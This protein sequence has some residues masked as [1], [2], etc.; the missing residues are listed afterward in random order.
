M[1]ANLV[2]RTINA[3]LATRRAIALALLFIAFGAI[4]GIVWLGAGSIARQRLEIVE[5][6]ETA[7]RLQAIA[8]LKPGLE[9][10]AS[11]A[12]SAAASEDFLEGESEAVIRANLQAQ[13]NSIAAA[14]N[15]TLQ[16]VSNLPELEIDGARFIGMRADLSGTVE[17]VHNTVFAI[18]TVKP[19]VI[20][21]TSIW[22][23][24]ADQGIGATQA[25][26]ISTQ[27]RIYGALSPD[28]KSPAAQVA[29]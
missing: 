24:G 11:L 14:Q 6:R 13:L 19:L 21:D 12:T 1:M 23:S 3:S 22:L 16:S 10:E 28:L 15:A 20:R 27:I 4:A 26:E 18:E 2:S 17:A 9:Q 29:P 8:A 7:G 25:P 5:K